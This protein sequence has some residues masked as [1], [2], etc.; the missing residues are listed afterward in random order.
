MRAKTAVEVWNAI[1]SGYDSAAFTFEPFA[2][3]IC[4][5]CSIGEGEQVLDV[6]CGTGISTLV[7]ARFVGSSGSAI[8]IDPADQMVEL[9][10]R[11]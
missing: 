4:R 10:K 6:G 1:A 2:D 9:A 8:G 3:W 7:A 11:K 5:Y